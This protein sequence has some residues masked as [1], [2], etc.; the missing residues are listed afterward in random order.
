[1]YFHNP[2][3]KRTNTHHKQTWKISNNSLRDMLRQHSTFIIFKWE[4]KCCKRY[5][6]MK[7]MN[8]QFICIYIIYIE[9]SLHRKYVYVTVK[10]KNTKQKKLTDNTKSSTHMIK[11]LARSVTANAFHTFSIST[12]LPE[13]KQRNISSKRS[14]QLFQINQRQSLNTSSPTRLF[15]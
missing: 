13:R 2:H 3:A 15:V 12:P 11:H 10:H 7:S 6:E 14:Q 1:M 4:K 5:C 8:A 9:K